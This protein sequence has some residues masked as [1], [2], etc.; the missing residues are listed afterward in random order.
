MRVLP[1][2]GCP[3]VQFNPVQQPAMAYAIVPNPVARQS[4]NQLF[5]FTVF[6]TKPVIGQENISAPDQY[7][8]KTHSRLSVLISLNRALAPIDRHS[9]KW[10]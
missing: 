8:P 4:E 6:E 10:G 1:T 9:A 5:A 2:V 3:V 7:R